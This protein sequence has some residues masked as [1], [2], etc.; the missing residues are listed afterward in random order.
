MS[1]PRVLVDSAPGRVR[2]TRPVTLT[3]RRKGAQYY[4]KR[5]L[6]N[7][8]TDH[9]SS[10][11]AASREAY[12][13]ERKNS[14][15]HE[16]VARQQVV[17]QHAVYCPGGARAPGHQLMILE[18]GGAHVGRVWVGPHPATAG[19]FRGSLVVQHRDQR[20]FSRLRLR[21][22][23]GTEQMHKARTDLTELSG[24]R[25]NVLRSVSTFT[26]KCWSK[27]QSCLCVSMRVWASCSV[28]CT[29]MCPTR[30]RPGIRCARPGG[31]QKALSTSHPP[32]ARSAPRPPR[33]EHN[34][35]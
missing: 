8:L 10:W 16:E 7:A 4:R 6:G 30:L 35:G 9:V 15:Q 34:G 3:T 12:V 18:N 11:A 21:T 5:H 31:R 28:P 27:G 14:G 19:C 33:T 2:T 17:E 22:V 29:Q 24:A 32:G 20:R 1:N 25:M 23:P 26:G 13:I